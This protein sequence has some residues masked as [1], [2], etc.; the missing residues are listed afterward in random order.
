MYFILV[1]IQ[2][3]FIFLEQAHISSL[4]SLIFS[5]ISSGIYVKKIYYLYYFQNSL[6]P[7]TLISL[8]FHNDPG[9]EGLVSL[10]PV[11]RIRHWEWGSGVRRS[12]WQSQHL[13]GKVGE[14]VQ[15]VVVPVEDEGLQQPSFPTPILRSGQLLSRC[16]LRKFWVAP[17]NKHL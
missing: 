1:S 2:N 8:N 13:I 9:R 6:C 10:V 17:S 15:A 12:K 5:I 3:I 14:G 4:P 7:Q 16:P 11:L